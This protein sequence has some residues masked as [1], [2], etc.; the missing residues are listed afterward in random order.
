[1]KKTLFITFLLVTFLADAQEINQKKCATTA[2]MEHEIRT[3]PEYKTIVENYFDGFKE[4]IE[5][6][7]NSGNL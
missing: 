1:M 3:N 4:W 2:I 5:K 7:P 6:N